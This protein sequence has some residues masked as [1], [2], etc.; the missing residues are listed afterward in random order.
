[1]AT[2]DELL[3]KKLLDYKEDLKGKIV[4]ANEDLA[5]IS[6]KFKTN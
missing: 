4:K 1:M 2:G 3:F 6:Y 5:K